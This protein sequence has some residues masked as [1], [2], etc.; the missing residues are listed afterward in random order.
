MAVSNLGID[1]QFCEKAAR[2]IGASGS[3]NTVKVHKSA[4][5]KIKAAESKYS[6]SLE[7]PWGTRELVNFTMCCASDNLRASTVRNYVSQIKKAHALASHPWSPD[8]VLFNSLVRGMENTS[9]PGK[10]RI[11]V[12]P[13]MLVA[14]KQKILEMKDSWTQHDRRAL[15]AIICCLWSGSFRSSELLAPTATGYLLEETFT[16]SKLEKH[17]DWVE[18]SR[19]AWYSILLLKPKEFRAGKNGV[20]VE[21]FSIPAVWDPVQAINSF[22]RDNVFKEDKDLPVFRWQSGANVTVRFINSFIKSC[23]I[24]LDGYPGDASLSSHSFRAGIVSMMG[25]MG[26]EET[27]IKAVGRW[28]GDSWLRYAKSGRSIRKSDQYKIQRRAAEDYLEWTP[29]SVMVEEFETEE[30]GK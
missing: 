3:W 24:S 21:L 13:R 11:A 9:D 26:Y 2:L 12:T 23:G 10:R 15:W 20:R 5:N 7:M 8:L 28:G 14:F 17:M 25:A 1:P 22:R 16:W 6:V 29:I 30:P 18:G 19:V 27:L 4:L